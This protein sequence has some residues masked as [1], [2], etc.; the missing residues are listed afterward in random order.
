MNLVIDDAE[1]YSLKN[2]TKKK[3]GRI[4]LKG[5]NVSLIMTAQ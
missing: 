5:E 2:N 3:V 4:M 1:E